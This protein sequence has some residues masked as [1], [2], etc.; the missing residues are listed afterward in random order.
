[1]RPDHG[2]GNLPSAIHL[3][4][5]TLIPESIAS[6]ELEEPIIIRFLSQAAALRMGTRSAL[7]FLKPDTEAGKMYSKRKST[8]NHIVA[9]AA[10][11]GDLEFFIKLREVGE[12]DCSENLYFGNP[13]RCAIVYDHYELA[14]FLL[15]Y[16]VDANAGG[17]NPGLGLTALQVAAATGRTRFVELLLTHKN[18]SQAGGANFEYAIT[19][20]ASAGHVEIVQNLLPLIP[21]DRTEIVHNMILM[22]A[23][24]HDQQEVIR[25][26]LQIG[27]DPNGIQAYTAHQQPL[28]IAGLRGN[29]D[30][31]RLLVEYGAVPTRLGRHDILNKTNRRGYARTVQVLLDY[32][33]GVIKC[34]FGK[35]STLVEPSTDRLA[36]LHHA[37]GTAKVEDIRDGRS[38]KEENGDEVSGPNNLGDKEEARTA[39]SQISSSGMSSICLRRDRTLTHPDLTGNVSDIQLPVSATDFATVQPVLEESPDAFSGKQKISGRGRVKQLVRKPSMLLGFFKPKLGRQT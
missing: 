29:A 27:A 19:Q 35:T 11:L 15:D 3:A 36:R 10:C 8:T 5:N 37:I 26:L 9:S 13:L 30:I 1:M 14:K 2:T 23:A 22:E 7:H 39:S 25:Y 21:N 12:I 34:C 24:R 4:A 38:E 28:T 32:D 17:L 6:Q 20:A 16:G 18:G 33:R 31:M